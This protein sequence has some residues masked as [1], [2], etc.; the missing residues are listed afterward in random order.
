MNT[1]NNQT[2]LYDVDCPLC[3]VYTKGFIKTKMLDN[4]GRKP[5]T[6]LNESE[7]NFVDINRAK[8]EIALIDNNKK[9][10]IYGIDSL[11]KI[12]GN[13]FPI[14]E[15]T[16]NFKPIK[17]LLKKLYSF[18]SYNRKVIMPSKID[19]NKDLQ[20]VPSFNVKYRLLYIMFSIV[21][22]GIVLFKFSGLVTQLPKST[23]ERELLLAFGQICFQILFLRHFSKTEIF[24]YI[25]SLMT[26]SLFGSIILTPLLLINNY[27]NCSDIIIL[28]WFSATLIIMFFEHYRR[29]KLLK[30]PLYLCYTWI[31]YRIIALLI[32]LN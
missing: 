4:N 32:I 29:V 27:I 11:L 26:V 2:L 8:D 23:I 17:Y 15:K 28:T 30:L 6:C 31:L 9:T 19:E 24:N 3:K 10:V 13:N 7:Q 16:G 1:L 5:F 12:I 21:I 20:C 14:I 25:G 22:T 18:I